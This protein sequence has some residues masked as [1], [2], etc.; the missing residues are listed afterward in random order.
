MPSLL[1]YISQALQLSLFCINNSFI[2]TESGKLKVKVISLSSCEILFELLL[3]NN[4]DKGF[5]PTPPSDCFVALIVYNP[6]P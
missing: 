1:M 3:S 2:I 5:V 6:F 4:S